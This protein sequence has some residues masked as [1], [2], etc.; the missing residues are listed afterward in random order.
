MI[1]P[2]ILKAILDVS[3]VDCDELLLAYSLL[4]C[5]SMQHIAQVN[6][7]PDDNREIEARNR[8][9]K[10]CKVVVDS[11]LLSSRCVFKVLLEFLS[12][13]NFSNNFHDYII[14]LNL[15]KSN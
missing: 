10:H 4:V 1:D 7:T 15:L 12:L 9:L 5:Q 11:S 14:L 13:I 6:S 2:D 8:P 3:Q